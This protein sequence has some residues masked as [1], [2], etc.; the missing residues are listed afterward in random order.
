MDKAKSCLIVD[1]SS[2]VRKIARII[3]E[4]LGFDVEEAESG[5]D[6]LGKCRKNMPHLILIDWQMPGMNPLDVLVE[7]RAKPASP[8]PFVLYVTTEVD[9][10]DLTRAFQAGADDY[11]MKP[12]NREMIEAKLEEIQPVLA[13]A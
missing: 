8:R 6:A 13:I 7:L 5:E 3:L 2:V 11:L 4:D 12:F 9:V 10:N 1:D